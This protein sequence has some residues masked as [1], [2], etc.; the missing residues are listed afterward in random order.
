MTFAPCFFFIFAGAPFIERL[1][2]NR[3]LA[4]A[5]AAVTAAIVGVIV[6]LALWFAVHTAFAQVAVQ[7]RAGV[8][9][10]VPRLGS[11]DLPA[12]AIMALALLLIFR[13]RL[14]V[15]KTLLI[16]AGIGLVFGLTIGT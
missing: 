6:N 15:V 12:L 16:C 3:S 5:L 10:L 7:R 2:G 1:R 13:W 8:Q 4:S 14:S 9:L 11:V